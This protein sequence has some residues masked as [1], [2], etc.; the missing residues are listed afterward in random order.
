MP[1]FLA[2]GEVRF[3]TQGSSNI[4]ELV[5]H[6]HSDVS[7]DDLQTKINAF[8]LLLTTDA[9]DNRPSIR[10]ITFH[11]LE[12]REN[13]NKGDFQYYCQVHYMLIGDALNP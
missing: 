9:F 11:T 12:K 5:K 4:A 6:F 3:P 2:Y 7:F 10:T 13:P 1:K 8:L